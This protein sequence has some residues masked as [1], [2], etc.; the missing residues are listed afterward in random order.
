MTRTA[1]RNNRQVVSR[2]REQRGWKYRKSKKGWESRVE[3]NSK[4]LINWNN[5]T[6]SKFFS[7]FTT[8]SCFS[9]SNL[10]SNI[11]LFLH[12]HHKWEP[13]R[14]YRIGIHS[15][16]IRAIPIHSDICIRAN[17]NHSEPIRNTFYNSFD[18]KR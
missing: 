8:Y 16:P 14:K 15:E 18:E 12:S 4:Y 10:F 11:Y 17:P 2:L 9:H 13:W 6:I 7:W 1:A 3:I 5:S